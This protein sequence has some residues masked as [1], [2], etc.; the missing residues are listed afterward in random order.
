MSFNKFKFIRGTEILRHLKL[1]L[2]GKML[3]T[4]AKGSSRLF[5]QFYKKRRGRKPRHFVMRVDINEPKKPRRFLSMYGLGMVDKQKFR[6]YWGNIS[7]ERF[8]TMFK[9]SFRRTTPKF[10]V[11]IEKMET[12]VLGVVART[13][14]FDSIFQSK[15]MILHGHVF[16]NGSVMTDYYYP[17][18]LGDYISFSD[19]VISA[20][21]RRPIVAFLN[22][23]AIPP[24]YLVVSYK[25]FLVILADWPRTST[26]YYP[27]KYDAI[28]L[29]NFYK[30]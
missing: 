22:R 28:K 5:R 12:T 26:A 14:F 4:L 6:H 24:S 29:L 11:F 30:A 7:E 9:S 16:V 3:G 10:E 17:L 27:F 18:A 15:Q 23:F 19:S 1:D 20:L 8:K 21:K 13:G 25:L 2:W